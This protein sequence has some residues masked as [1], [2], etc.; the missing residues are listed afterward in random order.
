MPIITSQLIAAPYMQD[1]FIDKTTAQTMGG[2]VVSMFHDNARTTYKNW[3]YQSGSPGNYT[4][5]PLDNP[6]TLSAA[7]TI[8]DPSGQDTI[9]FYYP[10][11]E[12]DQTTPD[13]Y[14]VVVQ[15]TQ[16]TDQFTRQNFPF[17]GNGGSTP[18]NQIP[19]YQNLIV[20]GRWWNNIG[21][22][23]LS[24]ASGVILSP[25]QHDTL[26]YPD[27]QFFKSATGAVE[28]VSFNQ[29]SLG[30]NPFL[31]NTDPP[32]EYYINHVCTGAGTET[33]KYYQIP[34]CTHIRNLQTQQAIVTIE[35]QNG[36]GNVNNQ[37][38][39]NIVG[40]LGSTGGAPILI[41]AGVINATSI[42]QKYSFPFTFPSTLG[43][44]IGPTNDDGFYLQIALQPGVTTNI[45]FTLPSVYLGNLVEG[46]TTSFE[47]YDAIDAIVNS[48]RTGD[49]RMSLNSFAPFGWVAADDGSISN[50]GSDIVNVWPLYN[51]IWNNVSNTYAPVAGGRGANAADDFTA[52]KALTLT[53]MLGRVIAGNWNNSPQDLGYYEGAATDSIT[54]T[55]NNIPPLTTE[56]NY[57]TDQAG[58]GVKSG[59]VSSPETTVNNV[60]NSGSPTTPLSISTIQPTVFYNVFF[61][62]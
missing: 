56:F 20:N 8:T 57:V 54:L 15:N 55:A 17:T 41:N 19:T 14:Y 26:A 43:A 35:V 38:Q 27:F 52:G 9:P 45:N 60:V 46:P 49:I 13:P 16:G 23:D 59:T 18:T 2:G 47:T 37:I 4:Y 40:N 31:P 58:S 50:I 39:L 30:V 32:C 36:A 7:G 29:F 3:Y 61:K 62:L 44:T 21:Y 25:S 1:I 48:P 53:K 22:M 42:W 33:Y 34:I 12:I 24:S 51:L 6:L 5:L 10:F 28:T 11:S